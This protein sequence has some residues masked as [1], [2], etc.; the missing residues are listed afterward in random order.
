MLINLF[1]IIIAWVTVYIYSLVCIFLSFEY[2][3]GNVSGRNGLN[4]SM[5]FASKR[6]G[7]SAN[8][9]NWKLVSKT[10]PKNQLNGVSTWV[11]D[12]R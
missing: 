4:L 6:R 3:V 9:R 1:Q 11:H 10:F 8:G 2:D 5:H 7:N 12:I